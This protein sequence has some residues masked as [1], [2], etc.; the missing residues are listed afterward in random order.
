MGTR[1]RRR[2]S[3]DPDDYTGRFALWSGTSF[4]APLF[5]GRLADSLGTIPLDQADDGRA[6]AVARSWAAVEAL[7]DITP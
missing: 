5:A 4:S 1:Q 2:E 6:A 7:T 3:I